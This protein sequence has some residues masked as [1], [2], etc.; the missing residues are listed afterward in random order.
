MASS[1]C[2][3]HGE[4][5]PCKALLPGA[6]KVQVPLV[7]RAVRNP[8]F[9]FL[10]VP[11]L[12]PASLE[13]KHLCHLQLCDWSSSSPQTSRQVPGNLGKRQELCQD[14]I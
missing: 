12:E 4:E 1:E 5:L 13:E 11:S 8:P 2:N 14:R 3:R 6:A 7:P 9:T 10:S